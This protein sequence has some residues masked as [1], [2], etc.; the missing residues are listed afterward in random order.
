MLIVILSII[1]GFLSVLAPCVLPLLPIIIGGSL[2]GTENKKR[3][4]IIIGSLV[5]SLILFTMLLKISTALIG[6]NP[7]VWNYISGGIVILL[8][9]TILFPRVWD[10]VIVKFGLQAKSQRLLG[11]AGQQKNGT[12]SAVL[13]GFA[14][15]PVFSSCSPLYGWVVATVLPESTA[16][17]LIYL[18]SYSVGLSLA[19]LGIA[20]LGNRLLQKITWAS[21]P[22][23]L[24]QRLIAILFILV[25]LAVFTGFDKTIQTYLVDKDFFN[26]KTLEE[27]LIPE[28]DEAPQQKENTDMDSPVFNVQPLDA[29]ELRGLQEWINSE[30]L[31]LKSLKGK[32]VLIDFWTYSCINCIRTLPYVQGWYD[33]YKDDGFVVLGLHAPEFAFEKVPEN[34]K[35]AVN[36]RKLTYPV[37]LDNDFATWRAYNNRFW[38][39]HYLIDKNGQIRRTHFGEGEYDETEEAIRLLLAEA[40]A[41]DLG[42][43]TTDNVK[44][45]FSTD[46]TPETYIGALRAERYT[47]NEFTTGERTFSLT[48]TTEQALDTWS[49]GGTWDVQ[50]EYSRC[51]RDCRLQI[52]YQAKDV[53]AVFSGSTSG[54]VTLPDRKAITIES[55]DLYPIFSNADPV[56]ETATIQLTPGLSIHAFTFGS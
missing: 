37:A 17:G 38:P 52:H 41:Q 44:V 22:H 54:T 3:P 26:L 1:A 53:Y 4:Y 36:D 28:D 32:V 45:P 10:T 29:P 19:L 31:T 43:A 15:G 49:L 14:L 12:L 35:R 24:F 5:F 50:D 42:N 11:S 48:A 51:I 27:K 21:N 40:G 25:G 55:E 6:I 13:T 18:A 9:L 46:Q 33:A 7:N 39:A 23:G 8:G 56:N 34:V 30:P 16:R 2:T 20:L 47:N